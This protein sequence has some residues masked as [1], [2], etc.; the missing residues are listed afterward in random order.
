M[1]APM[2]DRRWTGS[3]GGV[4]VAL[5]GVPAVVTTLAMDMPEHGRST[6]CGVIILAPLLPRGR[7]AG[8]TWPVRT[9]GRRW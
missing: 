6:I 4:G 8:E 9:S 5:L 7:E 3:P 1:T 2:E